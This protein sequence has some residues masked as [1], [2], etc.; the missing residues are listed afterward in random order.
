ME[1][2]KN[3]ILLIKTLLLKTL[4]ELSVIETGD[5]EPA[6][7]RAR[8]CMRTVDELKRELKSQYE[9]KIL[10]QFDEELFNLAKQI[11][12]KFDNIV[13]IKKT[14]KEL[15]GLKLSKL[16]NRKKLAY[17]SRYSNEY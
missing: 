3:K 6:F 4:E 15:L 2:L 16:Q 17:Y 10:M 7:S 5:F 9:T 14:Q 1:L 11:Q 8:S 12:I 13:E